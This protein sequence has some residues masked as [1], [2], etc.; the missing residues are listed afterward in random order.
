MRTMILSADAALGLCLGAAAPAKAQYFWTQQYYYPN[1][2]YAY[3]YVN[4]YASYYYNPYRA[5][6]GYS[7]YMSY[8]TPGV[9]Y[10]HWDWYNPYTNQYRTWRWYRRW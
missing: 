10:Y 6:Y 7:P 1:T 8:Y 5:Y 9:Q 3:S 2:A 4:P